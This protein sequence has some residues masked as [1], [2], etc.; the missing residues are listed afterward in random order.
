MTSA[1]IKEF[2]KVSTAVPISGQACV[3]LAGRSCQPGR[4]WLRG[5]MLLSGEF[6]SEDCC[7]IGHRKKHQPLAGEAVAVTWDWRWCS[8]EVIFRIH[9]NPQL[10]REHIAV[11]LV[12]KH[13]DVCACFPQEGELSLPGW[14]NVD[15]CWS[16][17]EDSLFCFCE[18]FLECENTSV[19]FFKFEQKCVRTVAWF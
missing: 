6:Y 2:R 17:P 19:D 12:H 8:V 5:W 3:R 1:H 15:H 11:L 7:T 14:V 13:M 18:S 4:V 16:I 9:A 10:S